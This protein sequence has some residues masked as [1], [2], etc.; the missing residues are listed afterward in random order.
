MQVAGLKNLKSIAT[1]MENARRAYTV[2]KQVT[3]A[4][5]EPEKIIKNIKIVIKNLQ[6]ENLV[7]EEDSKF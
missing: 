1:M 3:Y 4:K 5:R 6:M 7:E 2:E